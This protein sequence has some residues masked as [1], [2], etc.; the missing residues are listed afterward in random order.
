[1]TGSSLPPILLREICS[2][3]TLSICHIYQLPRQPLSS[4]FLP[5]RWG[6]QQ[7]IWGGHMVSAMQVPLDPTRLGK[8]RELYLAALFETDKQ[9]VPSCIA[10]A[11]LAM[12]Q[13]AREL[14]AAPE[15]GD[16]ERDGLQE[17]L[18]ALRALRHCLDLKTYDCGER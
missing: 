5:F 1:M 4:T 14:F 11:E 12:S 9:K 10:T 17:A 3:G 13:R 2:L 6:S 15:G 7:F 8:W 18:Y 16:E